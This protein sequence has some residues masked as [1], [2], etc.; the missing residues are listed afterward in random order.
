MNEER[1]KPIVLT[2]TETGEKYTLEFNREAIKFAEERMGFSVGDIAKYPYTKSYDLFY[3]AFRTHHGRLSKQQTD[4]MLDKLGG[5]SKVPV[6]F[7]QRLLALYEQ[8]TYTLSLTEE[9]QLAENPMIT[10][11]M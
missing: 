6:E 5:V 11:E 1:V 4:K 9:E 8:G 2:D 3:L 7:W 10:V